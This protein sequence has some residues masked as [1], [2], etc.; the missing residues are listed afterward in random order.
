MIFVILIQKVLSTKPELLTASGRSSFA[1]SGH[2]KSRPITDG[3]CDHLLPFLF[4]L[5]PSTIVVKD[6]FV[7]SALL[8]VNGHF[9]EFQIIFHGFIE[10]HHFI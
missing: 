2:E 1:V 9:I 7:F 8:L 4:F 6:P 3:F 10:L 5:R